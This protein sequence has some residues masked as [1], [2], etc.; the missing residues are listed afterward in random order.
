LQVGFVPCHLTP[1]IERA[2]E[3]K[4]RQILLRNPLRARAQVVD[5]DGVRTPR[6][7]RAP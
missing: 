3:E 4:R 6:A 7:L 1:S 2:S 5:A